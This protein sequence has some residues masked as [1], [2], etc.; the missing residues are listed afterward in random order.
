MDDPAVAV[1]A[2]PGEVQLVLVVVVAGEGHP[3]GDQPFDRS[4]PA[5]D[6][7][8]DRVVVAQARAGD[9]GVADVVLEG[10]GAVQD[11][12]DPALGPARGAVQELVLGHEGDLVAGLGELQGGG[13]AGQ[14]AADDQDVVV[15]QRSRYGGGCERGKTLQLWNYLP[16]TPSDERISAK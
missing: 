3:L 13:H 14:A 15:Q 10:I 11:G 5:L 4:A 9:V 6:H 1:A 16:V 12:R 8:A 7:E 2:L